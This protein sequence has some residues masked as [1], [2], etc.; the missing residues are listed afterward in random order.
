MNK[1]VVI[2]GMGINTPI[3]DNLDDYIQNLISGKS[4]ISKWKTLDTGRLYSKIGGD[5][6]EYDCKRKLTELQDKIPEEIFTPLQRMLNRIPWFL[7]VSVLVA[8]DAWTDSNLFSDHKLA[9]DTSVILSGH[10]LAQHYVFNNHNLFNEEPDFMDALGAV[11]GL[12]TS[13]LGCITEALGLH[14]AAFSIGGACASGNYALRSAMDEIQ[15]RN[16]GRVLIVAPILEFSPMEIHGMTLIEA[17]SYKSFNDNPEAASR[18]YDIDRE[19]FVPSHGAAA[20]VLEDLDQA[21]ARGARIYAEVLGVEASADANRKPNPS[22]E[23]QAKAIRKVLAACNVKADEID[24]INAHATST[25]QGDLCELA[26]IKD[27]LGKHAYGVKINAT[28]SMLGHTCWSAAMVETVAGILQ[29]Q[30]GK[31]HPSINIDNI[32]PEV[33]LDVC[34]NTAVDHDIQMMLKNSFGFGGLNCVSLIKRYHS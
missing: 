10:N 34:S 31:L 9:E 16:V 33:D 29:M 11:H 25:P 3:G 18:P 20:L 7:S 30:I 22:K 2:T 12:D 17:I 15:F 4:A 23:G 8:L 1:R 21:R 6:G 24:Y 27:A 32:D 13:H 28:K 14:G 5:L 19:G 26:S